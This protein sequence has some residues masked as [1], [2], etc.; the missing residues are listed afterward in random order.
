MQGKELNR[1]LSNFHASS[2]NY[3]NSEILLNSEC[4]KPRWLRVFSRT[5]RWASEECQN[6][7][8]KEHR[9]SVKLYLFEPRRNK[10]TVDVKVRS[11]WTAAPQRDGFSNIGRLTSADDEPSPGM[12]SIGNRDLEWSGAETCLYIAGNSTKTAQWSSP[13]P[14]YCTDYIYSD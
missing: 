7:M 1:T 3:Y 2:S 13:Q 10:W 11:F 5:Y 9:Q 4:S 6:C 8:L 14:R 12:H